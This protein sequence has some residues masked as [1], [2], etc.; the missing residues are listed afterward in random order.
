M[1]GFVEYEDRSLIR[2]EL[3]RQGPH[4]ERFA[5][6]FALLCCAQAQTPRHRR[7]T[8]ELAATSSLEE[9][10]CPSS[11]SYTLNSVPMPMPNQNLFKQ[12]LIL[13]L[14]FQTPNPSTKPLRPKL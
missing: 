12:V 14:K 10:E 13:N 5:R 1:G 8:I 6:C 4:E 9:E 3:F 7:F 2:V 11:E